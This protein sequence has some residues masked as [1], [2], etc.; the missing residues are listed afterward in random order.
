MKAILR[1]DLGT[2]YHKSYMPVN[3]RYLSSDDNHEAPVVICPS[4]K[5][6]DDLPQVGSVVSVYWDED[7]RRT[8][9]GLMR[10]DNKEEK[11][12]NPI[13]KIIRLK[14]R[15]LPPEE[16][17][18]NIFMFS[19]LSRSA[20][21][22]DHSENRI[23]WRCEKWALVITSE[24]DEKAVLTWLSEWYTPFTEEP[25]MPSDYSLSSIP[26]TA[27]LMPPVSTPISPT[28]FRFIGPFEE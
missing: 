21:M 12:A 14:S 18:M 5:S 20:W 15:T 19:D 22:K 7:E 26:Q 24:S 2:L 23:A 6:A 1:T 8:R 9:N 3:V 11:P 17:R 13:R 28:L 4:V 10:P 16:V 27:P 25:S